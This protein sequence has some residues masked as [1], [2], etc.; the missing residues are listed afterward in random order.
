MTDDQT[1]ERRKKLEEAPGVNRFYPEPRTHT[2]FL[3]NLGR[4]NRV[5]PN[6]ADRRRAARR[7][8]R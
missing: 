5:V 3:V 4:W 8:G 1:R 2:Q 7:R 6:R